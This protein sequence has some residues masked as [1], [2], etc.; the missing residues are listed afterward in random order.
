MERIIAVRFMLH[1]VSVYGEVRQDPAIQALCR[2]LA[3]DLAG[4]DEAAQCY[5]RFYSG[6]AACPYGP[7]LADYLF[8][9]VL[10]C[11]NYFS[12]QCAA[13]NY[14]GVPF[15]VKEAVQREL[16]ALSVAASLESSQVK[17]YLREKFPDHGPLFD[18]LPDWKTRHNKFSVSADWGDD[19]AKLG[20]LYKNK[21]CGLFAGF[22]A[23]RAVR[24]PSGPELVP[25][26]R[27]REETPP[28]GLAAP[29]LRQVERFLEGEAPGAVCTSA[30]GAL[31]AAAVRAFAGRSLRL[32]E[33]PGEEA[34]LLPDLMELLAGA[35]MRFLLAVSQAPLAPGQPGSGYVRDALGGSAA[36]VPENVLLCLTGAGA[37]VPDETLRQHF[38]LLL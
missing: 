18:L 31:T 14:I 25:L 8:G 7:N 11:D 37:S 34:G 13:N 24:R 32:V 6:L 30:G 22:Y 5:A 12:R 3:E 29:F 17:A 28:E 15:S 26:G 33:L 9:L 4:A 36:A 10:G 21:G 19:L 16:T 20:E 23:F 27:L 2:L 1:S 38:G 35:P